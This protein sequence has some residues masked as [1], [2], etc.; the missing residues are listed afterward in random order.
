MGDGGSIGRRSSEVQ[1]VRVPHCAGLAH[2]GRHCTDGSGA[3]GLCK[4]SWP[5]RGPI[6]TESMA[7]EWKCES[8][9]CG[10]SVGQRGRRRGAGPSDGNRIAGTGDW[11]RRCAQATKNRRVGPILLCLLPNLD[12]E[13]KKGGTQ[14]HAL[15]TVSGLVPK[16]LLQVPRIHREFRLQ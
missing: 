14:P 3:E 8:P 4:G 11:R 15:L 7:A 10:E 16:V 13:S 6:E 12:R 5:T 2:N 9:A 1:L